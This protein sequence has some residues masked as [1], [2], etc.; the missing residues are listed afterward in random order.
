M[1][2]STGFVADR[3]R[4]AVPLLCESSEGADPHRAASNKGGE[5]YRPERDEATRRRMVSTTLWSSAEARAPHTRFERAREVPSGRSAVAERSWSAA[6][7]TEN[8]S[9]G[10]GSVAIAMRARAA[11]M[12]TATA[13]RAMTFR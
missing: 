7:A 11:A 6:G 9:A 10:A 2:A 12:P 5:V 13:E 3:P 1:H 4:T 8:A